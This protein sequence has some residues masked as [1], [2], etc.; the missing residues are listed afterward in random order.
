MPVDVDDAAIL[1][2]QFDLMRNVVRNIRVVVGC[3][4]TAIPPMSWRRRSRA[5]KTSSLRTGSTASEHRTCSRRVHVD[6]GAYVHLNDE[7]A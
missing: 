3:K 7:R 6:S 1:P 2:A 5:P 4:W